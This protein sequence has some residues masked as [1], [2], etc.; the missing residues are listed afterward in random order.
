MVCLRNLLKK[1]RKRNTVISDRVTFKLRADP[2][3]VEAKGVIVPYVA[4]YTFWEVT[5]NPDN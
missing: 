2:N 5:P 3:P 1:E 4:Q